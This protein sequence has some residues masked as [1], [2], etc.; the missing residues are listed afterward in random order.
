MSRIPLPVSCP[1]SCT[2][3]E[4]GEL[5]VTTASEGLSPEQ[6]LK[7][8]LAGSVFTIKTAS[9]RVENRYLNFQESNASI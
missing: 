3:G 7:E 2:L 9:N 4:N 5:L 8:P 1:T 6:L